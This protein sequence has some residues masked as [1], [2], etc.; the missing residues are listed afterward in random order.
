M[1]DLFAMASVLLS[2]P[3]WLI[4]AAGG[5]SCAALLWRLMRLTR[6]YRS[7][8]EERQQHSE[9]IDHLSEGVY[10]AQPDGRLTSANAAFAR[11]NGYETEAEL[12][13]AV[14]NIGE[15]YVDPERRA[16]FEKA[17]ERDGKVDDFVSEVFRHKTRERIWVSQSA[18][19][20][21]DGS[22]GRPLRCEGSVREVTETVRRLHLHEMY[23]KLASQL[24]GGLFQL[25]RFKGGRFTTLYTSRG[26]R[27]LLAFADGPPPKDPNAFLHMIHAEDRLKYIGSLRDSGMRMRP[28]DCEFR[29]STMSGEQRW[30][31]VTASPEAVEN[32]IVWHG[33][34]ADVSAQKETETKIQQLAFYDPLTGLPNR[35]LLFDHVGQELRKCSETNQR[36]ALL[37]IDL[38]N[39]K[40]LNDTMG[41]DIGDAFLQQVAERLRAAV[42]PDD[43]VARIGGDEFVVVLALAGSGVAGTT[44]NAI[45]CANRVLSALRRE[46]HLGELVHQTSASV[47]VLVFD[48]SE[49]SPESLMKNADLAMYQVK[50]SGRNGVALFDPKVLEA[51]RQRFRLLNDL[52]IALNGNTLEL[53]YQPQVNAAGHVIGAEALLR[54]NHATRGRMV[55]GDFVALSEQFGLAEPLGRAVLQNGV[56]ALARWSKSPRTAGLRMAINISLQS[57]RDAEFVD[58]LQTLL[59]QNDVDPQLL[60]LEMA[61]R[62]LAGDHMQ[63]ARRMKELKALGVRLSL[64]DF[65]TGYSSISYLRKLPFDELKI[66]GSFITDIEK[67]ETDRAL[68]HSML[69]MAASLGLSV[70]AE[71]VQ[72]T[73][74]E[75]FLR[76]AGCTFFQGWRYAPALTE[77][78][79]SRFIAERN[80]ASILR[81]PGSRQEA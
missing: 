54:W 73:E 66:D 12:L 24:P 15:W 72:T 63:I 65:G 9:L 20:V 79:F 57:L 41:H 46:F 56:E 37:F 5:I 51:E 68:V 11:L 50:S 33:Y 10:R 13:A 40:T 74:Q 3:A 25:Q 38:D 81:F 78:R 19:L 45:V 58:F 18:R 36:G 31:R 64:D 60:T 23:E 69:S 39:F 28:W 26:F 62:V 2:E 16:A 52:R 61:E 21:R 27:Q 44:R 42:G 67:S 70:V 71:H 4:A 1:S 34:L 17:L 76:T 59:E 7:A 47:G 55:P 8:R 35:R 75:A 32:G 29:L 80:P 6:L 77:Q 49:T 48:G 30:L 43:T 14:G 53:H 22:S